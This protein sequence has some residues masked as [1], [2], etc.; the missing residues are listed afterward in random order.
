MDISEDLLCSVFNYK[1]KTNEE[2]DNNKFDPSRA[3]YNNLYKS[4]EFYEKKFPKG[5]EN[6]PGF[7]DVIENI[8]EKNNDNTPLKE[9]EKRLS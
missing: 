8:V 3:Q 4:Y 2:K 7:I 1:V 5:Y 6:I 9:Y